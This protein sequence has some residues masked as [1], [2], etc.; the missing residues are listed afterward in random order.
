[1]PGIT[2]SAKLGEEKITDSSKDDLDGASNI[3]LQPAAEKT[4]AAATAMFIIC[5]ITF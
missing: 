5:F 1:M 4:I 2:P 3:S